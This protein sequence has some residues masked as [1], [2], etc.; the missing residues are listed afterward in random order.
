MKKTLATTLLLMLLLLVTG[1]STFARPAP[2]PVTAEDNTKAILEHPQF[3]AMAR[4]A[5][6]LTKQVLRT[7]TRL[8]T[9]KANRAP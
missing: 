8:E 1:C 7:I 2:L 5:P 3:P 9:E 4:A 6:E